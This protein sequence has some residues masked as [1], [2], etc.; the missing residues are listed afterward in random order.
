MTNKRQDS[1]LAFLQK[2]GSATRNQVA[3][4][5]ASTGVIVSNVTLLRD[6]DALAHAKLVERSGAGKGTRYALGIY[7][8]L[9]FPMDVDAYFALGQDERKLQSPGFDCAIFQKM[10]HLLGDQ[11]I[12]ELDAL[13]RFYLQKKAKLSPGLVRRELDRF[14]IEF[15]WK[16][17]RMEGNTYTVFEAE[18]LLKENV[19]ASGKSAEDAQM[20]L[21]HKKALD[22]VLAS[23]KCFREIGIGKILELHRLLVEE[24]S[25]NPGIRN[26]RVGIVGSNY[27]PPENRVQVEAAMEGLVALLRRTEHPLER[28][29]LAVLLLSCI[30]P[31][32]D[33][34]KRTARILGNAILV[35]AN[36]CPLS[37]RSVDETGYRK[38]VIL[39]CEQNN[40]GY[41]RKLFLEQFRM[42]VTTYF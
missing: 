5:L 12:A 6:L 13:N 14:T 19:P 29:M 33:G 23:P 3:Q 21:N 41:F 28:A 40:L 8:S 31:F 2:A 7:S 26:G 4:H 18:H 9:T 30:Q 39:F 16:S 15:S 42:A 37:Y 11:D 27:S 35:A 20:L 24:L 38:A 32:E 22:H 25:I 1:I 34:N 17:S 36:Y 10:H